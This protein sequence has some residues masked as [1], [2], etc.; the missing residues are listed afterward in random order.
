MDALQFPPVMAS[1]LRSKCRFLE[2]QPEYEAAVAETD[3]EK[4]KAKTTALEDAI[5]TRCQK[6][7]GRAGYETE[8]D[9]IHLA[10][11]T[12]RDIQKTK[13]GYPPWEQYFQKE[14]VDPSS[15]ASRRANGR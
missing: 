15:P 2:W 12:L 8:H 10:I 9:A 11:D 3:I 5:F 7:A 13:L 4:L 6:I 1:R 14:Q